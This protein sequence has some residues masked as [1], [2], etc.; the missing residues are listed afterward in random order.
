MK[1]FNDGNCKRRWTYISRKL[2]K[3]YTPRIVKYRI[4][5]LNAVNNINQGMEPDIEGQ[6]PLDLFDEEEDVNDEEELTEIISFE[7]FMKKNTIE[8]RLLKHISSIQ[9]L[10]NRIIKKIM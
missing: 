6:D 10:I 7:D 8:I 3:N 1:A 2:G 5:L 4:L 9:T